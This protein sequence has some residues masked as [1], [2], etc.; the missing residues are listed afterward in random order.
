MSETLTITETAKQYVN[1]FRNVNPKLID[2]HF[3]PTAF[4]TGYFYDYDNKIWAP[5]SLHSFEQMREWT[6]TYNINGI[7]PNSEI[8]T[9][10]LDQQEKMAVVKIIAE[11]ASG[12]IGCDYIILLKQEKEWLISAVYWQSIA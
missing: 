8:K 5:L 11:W 2:K 10:L 7:M 1:A 12:V 4:K 9:T 6:K 3:I